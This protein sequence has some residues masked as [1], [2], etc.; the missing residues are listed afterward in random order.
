MSIGTC[1]S[2]ANTGGAVFPLFRFQCTFFLMIIY[3]NGL[4]TQAISIDQME[5]LATKA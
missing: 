1:S 4:N 3:P 5:G 2:V